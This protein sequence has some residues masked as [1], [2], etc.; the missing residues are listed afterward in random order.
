MPLPS[1][2]APN[3]ERPYIL[4]YDPGNPKDLIEIEKNVLSLLEMGFSVTNRSFGE[5]RLQPPPL[6]EGVG[7]MRIISQ[8]G[9]DRV[10]WDTHIPKEVKDAGKKFFELVK[11]G[12]QAFATKSDGEKGHRIEEFDPALGEIIMVPGTAPG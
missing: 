5:V 10:T 11:Q 7:I 12:Y 1:I 2:S 9:D 8:N 4:T 3:E 6:P